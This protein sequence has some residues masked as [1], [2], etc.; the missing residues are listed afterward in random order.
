MKLSYKIQFLISD[1][2]FQ[3]FGFN[4]FIL[5]HKVKKVLKFY[6]RLL[7]FNF[8]YIVFYFNF[9]DLLFVALQPTKTVTDEKPGSSKNQCKKQYIIFPL[10]K[11]TNTRE[12]FLY[13]YEFFY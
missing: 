8:Y 10:L 6:F 3:L 12:P 13:E 5:V 7:S 2:N 9:H 1:F 4:Y 11:P